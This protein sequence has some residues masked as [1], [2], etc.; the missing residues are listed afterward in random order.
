MPSPSQEVA[1]SL[2]WKCPDDAFA[3]NLKIAGAVLNGNSPASVLRMAE[4]DRWPDTYAWL[5]AQTKETPA[6]LVWA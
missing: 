6:G 2:L 1:K 3:D 5:K 4:T